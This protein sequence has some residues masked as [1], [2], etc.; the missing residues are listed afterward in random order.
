[1]TWIVWQLG[2][3]DLRWQGP[4]ASSYF[5]DESSS[6]PEPNRQEEYVPLRSADGAV[7]A[8]SIEAETPVTLNIF[9]LGS[10]LA[11]AKANRLAL[12][13]VLVDARNSRA[14]GD[15]VPYQIQEDA[16]EDEPESWRVIGGKLREVR[17]FGGTGRVLG[18]A[19]KYVAPAILTLALSR[20]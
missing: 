4:D 20:T 18:L 15:V 11:E 13:Q 3:L 17:Q 16:S 12:A 6:D 5:V 9:A 19:G 7:L 1:M 2:D 14:T 8:S 10:T